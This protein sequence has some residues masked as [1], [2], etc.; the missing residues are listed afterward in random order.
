[1]PASPDFLVTGDFDADGRA[2][3]VTAQRGSSVLY[4]LKGDGRGGF[5]PAA[6]VQLVGSVT[7]LISGEMNRADGLADLIIAVNTT[8]GAR[9]LVFEAPNGAIKAQPEIF[10]LPHAATAL[11]LARFDGGAMNDLAVAAGNQLVVIHARDR[12]L[13][14][15]VAERATVAPARLSQQTLGFAIQTITAGDF[16]GAGPSIAALG[17]DGCIHILEHFVSPKNIL[18]SAIANPN[19]LPSMKVAGHGKSPNTTSIS[20]TMTPG[21]KARFAAMRRSARATETPGLEWTERSTVTLPGGFAQSMPR[22]VAARISGSL[23]EDIVVP[24]SGSNQIHV[25][26]TRVAADATSSTTAT[27][28]ARNSNALPVMKK[29]GPMSL[30]GSLHTD[31]ETVALVPMR[32][33]QHGLHGLVMLHSG[34][35]Q[36]ALAEQTPAQTFVVTNTLDATTIGGTPPAGSLRAAVNAANSAGASLVEID[37]NIPTSD[38]GYNA[39][40]NTF[41]IQPL[42]SSTPG[43][44][45]DFALPAI[46]ATMTIDGYTQPGAS[47]NTSA[48]SDNAKILIRIDGGKATTPGGSGFAPFDDDGSTFRGMDF[49][50]WTNGDVSG[51]TESGAEG[52]EAGGVADFIEGNFFGTDVTGKTAAPNRIGVFADSG[53]GLGNTNSG[54]IIGGTTPQ[55][56][57]LMSGNTLAGILFLSTAIEA[58]LQGNF[59][60]TDITGTKGLPNGS[61]GAG[62]NGPTVTIGGTVPGSAN[63]ISCNPTNVDINDITEGG[64]AKNS[65]VQGN[66]LGTDGTGTVSAC[67]GTGTGASIISGPQDMTIGGTTAAARNVISGNS[68]GVYIFDGAFHNTVQGNYIGTD[69]TGT[70]ALGNTTAGFAS[71]VDSDSQVPLGDQ[72]AAAET[73]VGGEVPGAGNVISGNKADGISIESTSN[74]PSGQDPFLGNTILGN[75]IGTDA[76]GKNPLGNTSNGIHFSSGATSNTV[77]GTDPGAGNLIS[78]NG[79]N[80]VLIDPGNTSDG[81]GILNSVFGNIVSANGGVGV[82]VSTGTRNTISRNSIYNN[83]GLGIALGTGGANINTSCQSTATGANNSTNAPVLTAGSGTSFITATAT[84]PNGNTSQFSNAV[85]AT[86]SGNMLSLLGNFNGLAN[87][88][89]TIEFFSSTAKDP[90]GYGRRPDVPRL[91]GGHHRRL[92]QFRDQRSRQHRRCGP[93]H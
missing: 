19:F 43:S 10:T 50:G 59:I 44:F 41:L 47:P 89:Y 30:F 26:S 69:I 12:K 21:T 72:I 92:L 54:N 53:P 64:A 48:T 56:R 6:P 70:K 68:Y 79:M 35:T 38:P 90:S 15:G 4:F 40:T 8:N 84:D 39:T 62:L 34:E 86:A 87:S 52:I 11:A 46:N 63:V 58:S 31:R 78:N 25:F 49:T 7:A 20:G 67:P 80:G 65:L 33:N 29:S 2:D 71:G 77:G 9:A 91:H 51:G 22:L 75:F 88:N 1:M 83:G 57:N 14:L 66:L 45:N 24:D 37:F 82:L 73:A 42:S 23:Q 74:G 93:E 81:R 5:A 13:S 55:A 28:A 76:S 3:I 61:D 17:E 27:S 85:A 16:T 32:L 18:A 36:P 60:G